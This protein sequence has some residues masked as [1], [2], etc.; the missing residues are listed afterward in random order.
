MMFQLETVRRRL[1]PVKRSV[2]LYA[3]NWLPQ[4]VGPSN[5]FHL[6]GAF[7]E[8][9]GAIS[10]GKRRHFESERTGSNRMFLRRSVH[11]LEKGLISRPRRETFAADYIGRVV[12]TVESFRGVLEGEDP[13]E[14]KWATDVLNRYFEATRS[15]DDPR[16]INARDA[17]LSHW[18]STQANDGQE[19]H[20][21]LSPF[22]QPRLEMRAESYSGL[23][24][25]A[26]HRRS[27][28]WFEDRPVPRNLVEEAAAVGLTA[29]SACNRQS[30]R[31]LVMDDEDLR[32]R[33]AAVPM[34]TAGF[35]HQIPAL[36]VLIGQHRGYEHERDRHAIYVDGGLFA[37][38]FVLALEGLGL[39]SC[40]INWPELRSKNIE[41][42][43]LIDLEPDERI[44][45][46]IA[47]G[48]GIPDQLVPRSHK[49]DVGAVVQWR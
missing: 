42:K 36:G 37:S 18:D 14:L 23:A 26:F 31:L 28:R 6:S 17:W 39:N 46:L 13:G 8:E 27:V 24:R 29:P 7:R 32:R 9:Q 19:L 45:M 22:E 49:R 12:C 44:V 5:F 21:E 1:G 25:I 2:Q 47:I 11:R 41:M 48:Y 16:V 30:F 40:C 43:G 4:F 10:A 3:S 34:G 20:D 33:V 38:G 15:S 35:A